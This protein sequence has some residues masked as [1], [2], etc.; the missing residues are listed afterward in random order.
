MA[1]SLVEREDCD[2]FEDYLLAKLPN[3][4]GAQLVCEHWELV[5]KEYGDNLS[6]IV[7]TVATG[8]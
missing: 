8:G 6:M 1:W 4:R 7:P 5:F 3:D 2:S